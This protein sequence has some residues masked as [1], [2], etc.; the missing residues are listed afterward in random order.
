M[1]EKVQI[2]NLSVIYDNGDGV[3][4]INLSINQGEILTLLGPSGCGKTTIMRAIGGFN[5]VTAGEILIDGQDVT[6]LAPENRPTGMVFQSYNLWPHMTVFENL[7]FGLKLRKV[8]K[9][10]IKK[11][12][13]TILDLVRMPGVEEKFPSQLSGGQQQRV[14]IARS[15]LLKPAVLLL[16]EPFSALDAKIRHEMRSEIKRIRQDLDLTIVFVTHDQEEAMSISDRI[17]VMDK[18]VIAQVGTPNDI[19]DNPETQYVASFIGTMNF[20]QS[21]SG[22]V[23]A[24]RPEDIVLGQAGE[25]EHSATIADIMLI[26]HYAIVTLDLPNGSQ[27]Q[28]FISRSEVPNY[29]IGSDVSYK[30]ARHHVYAGK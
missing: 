17:V 13:A 15:L 21:E 24:S 22:E 20:D 9:A 6:N 25:Y 3:K 23:V 4:D 26:G 28:S 11:Q 1:V 2:N 12:V 18:G 7:A 30:V 19:Y 10:D 14:A 5:K 27:L 29:L 16:D 8:S